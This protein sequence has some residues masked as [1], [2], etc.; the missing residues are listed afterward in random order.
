M[1][2]TPI[3]PMVLLIIIP[4]KWLFH[5]EYTLFSDK[6]WSSFL[7]SWNDC[8]GVWSI[9]RQTQMG[10]C[11]DFPWL[12][13]LEKWTWTK[14]TGTSP[15]EN[16]QEKTS[17]KSGFCPKQGQKRQIVSENFLLN[18]SHLAMEFL[19]FWIANIFRRFQ[20]KKCGDFPASLDHQETLVIP[21]AEL[22]TNPTTPCTR[23]A[24][25]SIYQYIGVYKR[26]LDTQ[27]LG[28]QIICCQMSLSYCYHIYPLWVKHGMYNLWQENL[29]IDCF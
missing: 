2:C 24:S 21:P 11:W 26:L 22:A 13:V 12:E 14:E 9:F 5:W 19:H 23:H 4:I 7:A 16:F 29:M 3:N 1:L 28:T 27:W 18:I 20:Q 6:P 25:L 15:G 17:E 10:K 8:L